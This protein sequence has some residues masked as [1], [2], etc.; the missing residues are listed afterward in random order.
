MN[1]QVENQ[2]RTKGKLQEMTVFPFMK[3]TLECE[4]SSSIKLALLSYCKV[5][6]L[7]V[8]C[9]SLELL[10]KLFTFLNQKWAVKIRNRV[11]NETDPN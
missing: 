1:T 5:L 8:L 11:K 7:L 3:E 4:I 9:N 2:M 6:A 10:M